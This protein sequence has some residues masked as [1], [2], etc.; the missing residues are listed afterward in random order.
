MAKKWIYQYDNNTI[1]VENKVSG[2]TLTVNGEVQDKK[3][4]IAFRSELR[5]R[6][7]SGEEIKATLGGNLT[8]QCTLFVDNKLQQAE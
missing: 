2:E 8:V 3:T 1:L 4:G 5:G 7:P 6:L